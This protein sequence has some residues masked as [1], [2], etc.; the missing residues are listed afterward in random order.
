MQTFIM[1]SRLAPGT[2]KSPSALVEVERDVME[3]VR[4]EC[5]S[6]HWM[7]SYAIMGPYDY[8]DIIQAS[9]VETVTRASTLIR[10]FGRAHTEIWCATDWRRFK[11]LI[12][13]LPGGNS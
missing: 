4:V 10:T 8:L 3:R 7:Q 12:H 11:E 1:L 2:L 9:D 6:I 5:P 13:L